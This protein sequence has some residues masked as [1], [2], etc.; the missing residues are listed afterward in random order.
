M[1]YR[2]LNSRFSLH[3]VVKNIGGII[4]QWNVNFR[5]LSRIYLF[6]FLRQQGKEKFSWLPLSIP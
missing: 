4:K 5:S 6:V 2:V 3:L 1:S